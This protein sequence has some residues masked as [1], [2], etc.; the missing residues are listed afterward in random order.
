MLPGKIRISKTFC[1][2]ILFLGVGLTGSTTISRS[3]WDC[4]SIHYN[5]LV[6]V[7]IKEASDCTPENDQ[8]LALAKMSRDL[9]SRKW[10][11]DNANKLLVPLEVP[12]SGRNCISNLTECFLLSRV[13]LCSRSP[14]S[15]VS[16]QR[17]WQALSK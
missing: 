4:F 14:Q 5:L 9:F 12:L 16:W 17:R 15:S 10:L 1:Q 11:F 13:I 6:N 3:G 2:P 8:R 7:K